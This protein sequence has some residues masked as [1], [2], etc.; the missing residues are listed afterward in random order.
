MGSIIEIPEL[1]KPFGGFT[2]VS[3][4]RMLCTLLRPKAGSARTP[5]SS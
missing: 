3:G 2:A 1:T 5:A 4:I